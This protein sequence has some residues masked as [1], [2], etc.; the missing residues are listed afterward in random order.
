MSAEP[1][2]GSILQPRL[3]L[4]AWEITQAC[5]LGC[6]HCRASAV[7]TPHPGELSTEVCFRLVDQI[8]A[9]GKPIIIFTGGEPLLR[10]DVFSIAEYAV[11]S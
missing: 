8:C 7:D 9:L 11:A 2:E 5:N 3:Q 10:G 4:V 1:K 6:A